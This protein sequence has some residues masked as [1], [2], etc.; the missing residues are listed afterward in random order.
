MMFVKATSS[1]VL[2][3]S[4]AVLLWLVGCSGSETSVLEELSERGYAFHVTDFH[5]AAS[6]GEL[7]VI[8]LFLDSGMALD[9]RHEN[10][11][12]ALQSALTAGQS[13]VAHRLVELGAAPNLR[14]EKGRPPLIHAACSGDAALVGV[15]LDAGADWRARD[16]EGWCALSAA[17]LPGHADVVALL[18]DKEGVDV[19]RALHLACVGGDVATVGALLKAG[20]SVYA[21]SSEEKTALM[22]AAANGH[23]SVVKL[24][25]RNGANRYAID[26]QMQTAA[27]L[28]RASDFQEV[29]DLL[30]EPQMDGWFDHYSEHFDDGEVAAGPTAVVV[31]V[32]GSLDDLEQHLADAEKDAQKDSVVSGS[33][34]EEDADV[35][36]GQPLSEAPERLDAAYGRAIMAA[37]GDADDSLVPGS[38]LARRSTRPYGSQEGFDAQSRAAG[39]NG[40]HA[41]P[42]GMQ[43]LQPVGG[44]S[45][46]RVERLD[47]SFLRG[48]LMLGG[49]DT[50]GG[51]RHG[52]SGEPVSVL[53]MHDY[54][55][56]Q[57]P[58]ILVGMTST[59]GVQ[60][61]LVRLLHGSSVHPI[62]VGVGELI[63]DSGLKV[64]ELQRRVAQTK[65]N[66][67]MS[68]DVSRMIVENVDSGE[69]VLL[70]RG[71]PAMSN[72]VHAVVSLDDEPATVYEARANDRFTAA[73]GRDRYRVLD[74]RP[75]Q[76]VV[77]HEG[78]GNTMTVM[79]T[80]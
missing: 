47:G 80:R 60:R 69:R 49:E 53:R 23:L 26:L 78:S 64:I 55:E 10:G 16:R 28:A 14:D 44:G 41:R 70:V 21:R 75:K 79:R 17:A 62:E 19:D 34:G 50:G 3:W 65:A 39:A 71:V 38:P 63:S 37:A 51:L 30:E 68:V 36:S 29:A 52:A 5:R 25:I 9:A 15:L 59:D 43:P 67:G 72:K 22:Y 4:C 32:D 6:A 73:G 74:V 56:S 61:G 57:L 1:F 7:A 45:G 76:M 33:A 12:T 40:F 46:R 11:C 48:A 42:R 24:L 77:L 58:V 66:S 2:L 35:E 31:G 27:Q 54:R 8:E 13:V 20:G 18:A